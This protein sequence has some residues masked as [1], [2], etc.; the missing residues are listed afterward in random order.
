[1]PDSTPDD[2]AGAQRPPRDADGPDDAASASGGPGSGGSDSPGSGGSDLG[3]P[4]FTQPIL[5]NVLLKERLKE[6]VYATITMLAVV[7]SLAVGGTADH[8]DAVWSILGT[9]IGVWL[10]TFVADQQAHRAV[11][12]RYARSEEF[13]QMLYTSSPLLLSAVGPLVFTGV[14]ALGLMSLPVAMYIACGLDL[15]ELFVWST[16][17]GL[18]MGEGRL[19]ALLAGAADMVIGFGIVMVKVIGGH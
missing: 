7:V 4:A 15:A 18:R 12:H 3:G 16:V 19:A 6:R 5:A 17:T 9:S 2:D 14:S 13:R 1:M 10:A 11:A 8:G